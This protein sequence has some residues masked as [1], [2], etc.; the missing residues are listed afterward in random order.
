MGQ[1]YITFYVKAPDQA[2]HKKVGAFIKKLEFFGSKRPDDA[3]ILARL[4]K[5][6]QN[7]SPDAGKRAFAALQRG[8]KKIDASYEPYELC[9]CNGDDKRTSIAGYWQF[10]FTFGGLDDARGKA[11]AML[12]YLGQ[13][14]PDIDVRGFMENTSVGSETFVR[15]IDG[16]VTWKNHDPG[17]GEAKDKKAFE[18]GVYPWWHDGL[19]DKIKVGILN[20]PD[21]WQE[22]YT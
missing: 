2:S 9:I 6:A 13:L 14:V 20:D 3:E 11:N 19:P 10:G 7:I 15:V 4:E 21:Y 16:K 12:A 1:Q 8:L 17:N 18:S 5:A 22:A